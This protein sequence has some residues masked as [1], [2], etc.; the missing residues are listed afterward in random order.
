MMFAPIA[1]LSDAVKLSTR[2]ESHESRQQQEKS[3]I[4]VCLQQLCSPSFPIAK[5]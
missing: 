3:F 5:H 2:L 4:S 1:L